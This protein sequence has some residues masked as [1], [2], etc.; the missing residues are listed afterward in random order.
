MALSTSRTQQVLVTLAQWALAAVFIGAALPKLADPTSFARSIDNYRLL[1]VD[2][3]PWLAMFL[4]AFELAVGLCLASGIWTRSAAL[5][6]AVMLVGFC[7][8][9]TQAIVRNID[10]ECGC[11]GSAI[12]ANV[13]WMSVARNIGLLGLAL[14]VTWKAPRVSYPVAWL[15]PR[16]T[17]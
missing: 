11:F 17:T 10:L 4:P 1:P 8:G 16:R 5:C 12:Q 13:S 6:C 15:K 7:A 9:M 3:A 2:L 14:F